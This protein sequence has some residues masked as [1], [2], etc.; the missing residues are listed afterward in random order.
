[1]IAVLNGTHQQAGPLLRTGPGRRYGPVARHPGVGAFTLI[2]LLIV[3]AIM[4]VLA[5]M[6][7]VMMTVAQRQGRITNSKA[8]MMQ[9][10]QAIRLFRTDM[11][12]YPWQ[13]DLGTPPA[14]PAAWS[15]NLAWRLAWAPPEAGTGTALNPDRFTYIK[16]FQEVCS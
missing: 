6:L 5:S 2:E 14:E 13:T 16:H 4:A 8:V 15:N 9:V 7:S 11:K 12:V 10:D 1:M 3:M